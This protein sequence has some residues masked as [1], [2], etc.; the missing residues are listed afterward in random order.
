M[1]PTA[2]ADFI[3]E[4]TRAQRRLFAFIY[5]LVLR[6]Q[7]A[8]DVLQE[9]NVVLWQKAAEFQPG[10]DF[11]AWAFRIAQFQVLAFRKRRR[12]HPEGFDDALLESLA[13]EARARTDDRRHEALRGCLSGLSSDQRLLLALR[14]EPGGSVNDMARRSKRSPKAMSEAL[15]R[16]RQALLDCIRGK[17]AAEDAS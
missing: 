10:T 1:E 7:D 17:L 2:S 15:R 13:E 16:I 8:E 12:R 4:V 14:Y 11:H 6:A 9:T 3:R 5:S